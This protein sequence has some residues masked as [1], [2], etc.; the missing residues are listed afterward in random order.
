M[1]EFIIDNREKIKDILQEKI[2]DATCRNL[3]IG[4][5]LFQMNSKPFLIIERKTISDMAASIRD[6]RNRE[7]KKRL[8][9][10]NTDCNVIYLIEGD[11]TINNKCFNYNKIDKYTIVSSIINTIIRDKLQV[12]HTSDENET[13]FILESIYNKL[14][15]QGVSFIENKSTHSEDIV[16]TVQSKKNSNLTP[17]I[18]FKMMLNC[19]PGVSTK[20]ST[21]IVEKYETMQ[22][23]IES[24]KNISSDRVNHIQLLKMSTDENARKISKTAATNIVKYL[25]FIVQ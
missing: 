14:K 10:Y 3:E 9:N 6:G 7:Q 16:N 1:V 2:K 18:G 15:K 21:R 12:F 5:Y 19:I 22:N 13:I 24:L 17:A 8:T 23:F 20:V 11:L 25:G 4:D